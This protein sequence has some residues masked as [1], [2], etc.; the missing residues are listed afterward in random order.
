MVGQIKIL[1]KCPICNESLM[2]SERRIDDLPSIDL[3]AKVGN[4]FGHIY[5]SQI[6][7]SYNKVFEN[8]DDLKDSLTEF[9]CSHC[10]SV[11]PA[12]ETCDCKAD[13]ISL[14]LQI[15]GTIK[16]CTRNGCKKHSLEFENA[17]DAFR[18]FQI[19]DETSLA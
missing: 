12:K 7:G 8:V 10:N 19:Q 6:Y 1:V 4:N 15:G 18:L 2:N 14:A 3:K 16:F 13:I 17:E 5:L 11:F 9:S